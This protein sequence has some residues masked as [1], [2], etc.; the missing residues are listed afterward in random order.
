MG[1]Q[2]GRGSIDVALSLGDDC[3]KLP[4][5]CIARLMCEIVCSWCQ[6]NPETHC[7][8]KNPRG[9]NNTLHNSPYHSR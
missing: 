9:T 4:P 6:D 5:E 1:R 3:L 2:I 8:D 7:Q